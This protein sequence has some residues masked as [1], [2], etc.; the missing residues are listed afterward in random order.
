MTQVDL[1]SFKPWLGRTETSEDILTPG[2]IDKF[3]ATF[4][5][6]LWGGAGDVPLGF[7]GVLP[8]IPCQLPLCQTM[9]MLQG[10]GFCPLSHCPPACGPAAMLHISRR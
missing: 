5:P 6:H 10:V 1:E 2:L 3:R 7:I 9:A 4:G 8:L